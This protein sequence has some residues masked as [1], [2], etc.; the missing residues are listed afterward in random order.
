MAAEEREDGRRDLR[1]MKVKV[2]RVSVAIVN[3]DLRRLNIDCCGGFT[4]V[5]G[6]SGGGA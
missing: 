6:D 4:G 1:E 3:T 5:I 2:I